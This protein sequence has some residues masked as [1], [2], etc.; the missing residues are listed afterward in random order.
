MTIRLRPLI[1]MA[2]LGAFLVFLAMGCGGGGGGTLIPLGPATLYVSDVDTDAALIWRP[3][4]GVNGNVMAD[5]AIGGPI[6]TQLDR[7]YGLYY[8]SRTDTVLVG[9]LSTAQVKF[10]DAVS[11]LDGDVM[12]TRILGGG[13]TLISTAYEVYVDELR[14]LLYVAYPN[15]ILVFAN[16]GTIDGN[17]APLHNITGPATGLMTADQD[18]RL[19]VDPAHDRLYV[20][21]GSSASVLV[22]NDASTADGNVAPARTI[23]GGATGLSFPWGIAVD[24]TRDILYVADEGAD[25][26]FVFDGASTVTGNVAPNR[27]LSGPTSTIDNPR[28]IDVDG[29][30]DRLYVVNFPAGVGTVSIWEGASGLDGD[31]AP[32]RAIA[33]AATGLSAPADVVI[34]R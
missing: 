10:F 29:P 24:L 17:V 19:F 14:D 26:L 13:L 3:E 9:D 27:T 1:G 15:G 6:N 30:T 12:P 8:D 25:A 21:D 23:A 22:F 20:T 7:P 18:K 4:D 2:M 5:S 34:S 31:V 11:G 33:G 32:A 28:D 16:A